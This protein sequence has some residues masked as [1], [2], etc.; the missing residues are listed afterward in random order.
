[1]R[2]GAFATSLAAMVMAVA[3]VA[4][5]AAQGAGT[6][7]S[8]TGEV[9]VARDGNLLRAA[10]NMSLY[11]GDRVVTRANGTAKIALNS[12]CSQTVGASAMATVGTAGCGAVKNF[13][14][15]RAGYGGRSSAATGTTL[16]LVVA[17]VAAAGLGIYEGVKN[18]HND[19]TSP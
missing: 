7:A 2:F 5:Q 13:D 8:G 15:G 11:A 6:V 19:R 16:V 14:A 12:G 9:F 1:M 10:P 18:K 17:A 4:V 3:R